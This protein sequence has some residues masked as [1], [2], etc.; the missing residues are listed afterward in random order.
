MKPHTI[1]PGITLRHIE[2]P[3]FTTRLYTVLIRRQLSRDE[4]T[5]NALLPG[6]L[7]RGSAVYPDARSIQHKAETLYGAVIEA[8]VVKKG[9]EQILQFCL[10]TMRDVPMREAALFLRDVL[11]RPLID[12]GAFRAMHVDAEREALRQEIRGRQDDK[13]TYARM[14]CLE[15]MCKNEPFGVY[16]DGYEEDLDGITQKDLLAQYEK[17]VSQAPVEII[18]VGDMP[19]DEALLC[20]ALLDFP[21]GKVKEIPVAE[22]SVRAEKPCVAE[23]PQEVAQGKLCIGLRA[24][25]PPKGAAYYAL[26][27]ANA[28]FGGSADSK[29]FANVREKAQICYYVSSVLYRFK[30]ILLIESGIAPRDFEKAEKMIAEQLAQMQEGAFTSND[31]DKAKKALGKHLRGL[32]DDPSALSDF[33]L[34]QAVAGD[35]LSLAEAVEQVEAVTLA[36]CGAAFGGVWLDTT[37]RLAPGKG[38][39]ADV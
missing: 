5:M 34:S 14:R 36:D 3:K 35:A 38:G 20:A 21:R 22:V 15:E 39:E 29:L 16:G 9:E 13:R 10:E 23:E 7:K 19:E 18:I 26:L 30:S 12:D 17:V 4:V 32:A 25:V 8:N 2:T 24:D 27:V 31:L 6:V 11:L 1:A 28:I 33:L 37:Y